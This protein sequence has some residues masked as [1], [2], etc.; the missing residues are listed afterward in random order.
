MCE[1]KTASVNMNANDIGLVVGKNILSDEEKFMILKNTWSPNVE[2]SF[3]TIKQGNQTRCFQ[4]EW[5]RRFNWLA[6]SELQNGG[7]CK[8][9]VCFA[10]STVSKAHQV[11]FFFAIISNV[12]YIQIKICLIKILLIQF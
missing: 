6:Y 7:F 3:P 5:L 12:Y 4:L 11:T 9:C 10:P 1:N 2:Y 8:Y